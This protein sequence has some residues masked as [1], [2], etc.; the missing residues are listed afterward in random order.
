MLEINNRREIKPHDSYTMVGR[1]LSKFVKQ[2]ENYMPLLGSRP[3]STCVV[4]RRLFP[5]RFS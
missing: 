1:W 3:Q 5:Q 4:F 2:E